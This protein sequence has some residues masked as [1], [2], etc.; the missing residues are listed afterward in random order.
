[1][2]TPVATFVHEGFSID[3][4][5]DAD[6]AAGDIVD[7]GNCV[8]IA[9]NA[10]AAN[11]LGAL[12]VH[13]V[14]DVAKFTGEAI[15]LWAPV[16]YDAGT[17]TATGTIGYSEAVMGKCVKAAASGDATVRVLILPTAT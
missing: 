15:S 12:Q 9:T 8:G 5:P 17:N 4:T 1:M 14:Y 10:I 7:L 16:Y 11:T 13:G 2:A 3:Y 6:V